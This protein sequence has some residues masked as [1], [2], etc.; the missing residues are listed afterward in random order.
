M[1]GDEKVG[2]DSGKNGGIMDEYEPL[3]KSY[4]LKSIPIKN[5][6]IRKEF[7]KNRKQLSKDIKK[8]IHKKHPELTEQKT[9]KL[10]K[11]VET[12]S[13]LSLIAGG[14]IGTYNI[15]G[16]VIGNYNSTTNILGVVLILIG[17]IGFVSSRKLS[18]S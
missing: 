2:L 16:N 18:S 15:T 9:G 6:E 3:K 12:I 11:T 5:K 8:Y 17:I 7:I 10:E 13:I 14:I 4:F 1:L